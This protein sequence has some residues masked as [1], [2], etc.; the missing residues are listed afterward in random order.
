MSVFFH[1]FVAA[2]SK[3]QLQL[4]VTP[5]SIFRKVDLNKDLVWSHGLKP[6]VR[7]MPSGKLKMY[8]SFS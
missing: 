1:R 3:L 7:S 6:A 4:G 2:L 5:S 8:A